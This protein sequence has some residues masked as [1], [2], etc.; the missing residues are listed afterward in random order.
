MINEKTSI[1]HSSGFVVEW[2]CLCKEITLSCSV[3]DTGYKYS[4]ILDTWK[5]SIIMDRKLAKV[6]KWGKYEILAS[7]DD[8]HYILD[9][10]NGTLKLKGG[11]GSSHGQCITK[12]ST[13]F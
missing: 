13:I 6:Q 7:I 10:V 2:E 3:A 12:N 11:E 5:K 9:R 1:D 4:I 8:S